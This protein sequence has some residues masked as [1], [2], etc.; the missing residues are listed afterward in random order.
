MPGRPH[1]TETAAAGA[2][3]SHD[4]ECGRTGAPALALVGTARLIADRVQTVGGQDLFDVPPGISVGK[5]HLE[6]RRFCRELCILHRQSIDE[7]VTNVMAME[8]IDRG[9]RGF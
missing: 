9:P 5:P 7:V 1:R 4:H 2:D 6:P 3:I 8:E